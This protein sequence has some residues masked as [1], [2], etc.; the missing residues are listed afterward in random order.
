MQILHVCISGLCIIG[1]ITKTTSHKS[2]VSAL[3]LSIVSGNKQR[4]AEHIRISNSE[5]SFIFCDIK[6]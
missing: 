2:Y 3:V 6:D 5:Y 1:C 4:L